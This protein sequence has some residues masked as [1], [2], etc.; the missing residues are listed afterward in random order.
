MKGAIAALVA[1]QYAAT[2]AAASSAPRGVGPEFVKFYENISAFTCLSNPKIQIPASRVNDDYCDCPDGSDE[3]GTAACAYLSDLSPQTP[4]TKGDGQPAL[5]GFY[6]QNKGHIPSYVPFTNVNDGVCDY[7]LCCDGSEE[8]QAVRGKCKNKCDEIGKE[9]RK[10]DEARQ[11]AATNAFKKRNELVKE[12]ARLRQSVKDRLQSLNTEI[13]GGEIKVKQMEQELS[14]IQKKEAGKIMTNSGGPGGKLGQLVELGKSRMEELRKHLISTRSDLTMKNE[15][16]QQLER[17]LKTFHEEYNPNF[18]DE[19]VK[20][21]VKAW[22]DYIA[23][24]PTGSDANAA[25][26]RDLDE[27]TKTD[28]ENGLNWDEYVEAEVEDE[29]AV[30]YSFTSYLPASLRLWVDDQYRNFRQSLI[31]NGILAD[32]GSGSAGESHKVKDARSRL[33]SAK[34]DL[35]KQQK[36]IAEHREDL[37]KDFGPDDV[38]RALK[39]QCVEKDS[40]EYTYEVCFLDKTTQKPKKGGGHTN[41][42]N[43]VRVEKVTVGEELPAD[44]KGLG[45]GERYA[46]KHENGQ[47]CWNGPNRATTVILACA[48]ENEIWKIMEEEKCIYRMEVGTPA[49]CE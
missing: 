41:M 10:H 4:A 39:G 38:F 35:E 1:A 6:C 34:K 24:N 49:V 36:D 43:F 48:E 23:S 30:L 8:Y 13:E 19:G 46:M 22:E 14:D 45:T 3:P 47:H 21:A 5:P 42:G 9:W 25:A 31:D 7:E 32:T 12:A 26:E 44:G 20:R 28:E 2:T 11:K 33:E 16:L 15:R 17:I 18:N 37:E 29:T 40:G 27:I